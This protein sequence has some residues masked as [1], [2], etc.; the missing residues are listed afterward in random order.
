MNTTLQ[1]ATSGR[2]SRTRFVNSS[3]KVL[4][5]I[6]CCAGLWL[7]V[8]P[9]NLFGQT[10]PPRA[11]A[12][13]PNTPPTISRIDDVFIDEDAGVQTVKLSGISSGSAR[14]S[15][16]LTVT[17]RSADT[18]LI[19]NPTVTYTSPGATGVLTFAPAAN[20]N[21]VTTITVTVNDGGAANNTT[22]V[23]FRVTVN[24]VNDAP[25]LSDIPNQEIEQD[26]SLEPVRF[27]IADVDNPLASLVV[28]AKSSNQLL[29][30][31]RNITLLGSEAIRTV[32]V[33]P[34]PGQSGSLAIAISVSDGV[35][36]VSKTFLLMV[37]KK[38]APP[39]IVTQ[40]VSQTV[41]PGTDVTFQVEA[42]GDPV[43]TYQWRFNE[44]TLPSE[45][46][47]TLTLKSVQANQ[48]GN[49]DVV[50]TNPIGSVT[51]TRATLT[52]RA[53]ELDFGDAPLPYPTIR[54]NNGAQHRIVRGFHLGSRVDAEPDGQ[55]DPNALGDDSPT[56]VSP[57]DE[58]G[59]KFVL[60]WLTGQ[61]AT[62]NVVASEKGLLDAWID[63][64]ANGGW[65]E[66]ADQVF[67]SRPLNAGTNTLTFQVPASAR[68]GFTFARF[69]FSQRGGLSFTGS[70]PDGEVE[71]YRVPISRNEE[72]ADVMV[73]KRGTPNPVAVGGNLIY[74]LIVQNNGPAP[75]NSVMVTD[76]LPPNVSYVSATSSQGNSSQTAG[77]VTFALGNMAAGTT[78]NMTI[79]VIPTS[80]ILLTNTACVSA[81]T[82]DPTPGNNC[83]TVLTEVTPGPGTIACDFTN[84]GTNFWLT[85]PANYAPDPANRPQLSLHLAGSANV[86]GQVAIPGL[87]FVANWTIPAGGVASVNLPWQADLGAL[88]DGVMNK[89]IHITATGEIAVYAL[90]HVPFTS[91]AYLGLPSNVLGTEYIVLSY[92][93]VLNGVP[94]LNGTQFAV[95]ATENN[96]TVTITPRVAAGSRPAGI[97]FTVAM[98]RG[99]AYQL[100]ST[101]NPPSDLSG[102][103]ITA[104]KPIGV[105]GGHRSANINGA[106]QFFC[107]TVV[108][109]LLPTAAWGTNF[110]AIPLATRLISDTYRIVA[111][112]TNTIVRVNGVIAATLQRG[113]VHERLATNSVHITSDK[114][115]LVAQYANSSDFDAVTNSD[116]FM[117]L[118]PSTRLFRDEYMVF[119][120]TNGFATNF[121]NIVAP[122]SL[123]GQLKLDGIVIGAGSF[124]P[125]PA[126]GPPS[127]FSG[128]QLPVAP[129]SHTL[130]Q[131]S[132]NR[133]PFGVT[134]YGFAEF[135]SY[136]YPGGMRFG[137]LQPPVITCPSNVLTIEAV[138][139]VAAV[140]SLQASVRDNCAPENA[141]K[142]AQDPPAGALLGPGVYRVVLRATDLAG[143]TGTCT[144][145][146]KI[147]DP[148]PPTIRCPSNIVVRTRSRVGEVVNFTATAS[149]SCN[150]RL[151]VVCT[152]ASGTTFPVGTTTVT[153][154]IAGANADQTPSRAQCTFTVTVVPLQIEVSVNNQTIALSWSGNDVLESASS[155]SGPWKEVPKA[156]SPYT[157]TPGASGIGD[158]QFYRLRCSS[159]P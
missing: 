126:A 34:A 99:D 58:D 120:M 138:N 101:N 79:R 78:A 118:I 60:P 8:S 90:N 152:P 100:R 137:D 15:Q 31:D 55:P 57:G 14:E 46:G 127:G 123:I 105:F 70:A 19:P 4:K 102:T 49:Y 143:N 146:L 80:A 145:V 45:V 63:F 71:D 115:I 13:A 140:P 93:N 37:N 89:G 16:T 91:D 1:R 149:S 43:L 116:P 153:C 48:G 38:G 22:S 12:A 92:P 5:W 65:T 20:A 110:V 6:A 122:N 72:L 154:S 53:I 86:T 50:V 81:A 130:T 131:G 23:A 21:G 107:D 87:G 33:R 98:N 150:P 56:A 148:N 26:T 104:D 117:V 77:I 134:V 103:V 17:A 121:I 76:T 30:P 52:I 155:V 18:A 114:P 36:V 125:I 144:S 159:C 124:S 151:E 25:V 88:N 64:D 96:T 133:Q 82:S 95:V 28:S 51:S 142:I 7:A 84:K 61:T 62:V 29:V 24:P 9:P 2:T 42:V 54:T 27:S 83:S 132:T 40:P 135:D 66:Q 147:L 129:G 106:T 156:Q 10:V 128:A 73:V 141:L 136:G 158:R 35:N 109:Q 41:D 139:C 47:S 112:E 68:A 3:A 11:L 85:F 59:V 75:A 94:E 74:T 113:E 108:E 32:S 97:P 67:A 111:A 157:I 44:K 39:T 119:S 69:R